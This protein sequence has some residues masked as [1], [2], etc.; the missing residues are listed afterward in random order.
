MATPPVPVVVAGGKLMCGH[1]GQIAVP[2]AKVS[3]RL[4]V[5][6]QGVLLVGQQQ[7]L[8]FLPVAPPPLSPCTHLTTDPT[9]KPA[10][11]VTKAADAKTVATKLTV[12]RI[13]VVLKTTK[14]MTT[15]DVPN[16]AGT[17]DSTWTPSE[18]GQAKLRAV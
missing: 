6:A 10:P 13:A 8:P 16:P 4:T 12:G 11:C 14:G 18:P 2:K 7:D 9:P 15:T 5:A 3:P 1:G 17:K